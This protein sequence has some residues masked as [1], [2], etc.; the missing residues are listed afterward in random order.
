MTAVAAVGFV[1]LYEVT[2]L[3]SRVSSRGLATLHETIGAA[4]ARARAS[5]SRATAYCKGRTTASGVAVQTRHRRRRPRAAAGR[6][7]HPGRLAA[8]ERYNGI[9][10]IMDTGPA[11]QG[12]QIDLYM[13][14]CNEALR[15]RP[16]ADPPSPCCA[17]AGTRAP[18]RRASRPP[19][20][21]ARSREPEPLPAPLPLDRRR[22][23]RPSA[24]DTRASRRRRGAQRSS[25]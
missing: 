23:T 19:V 5:P 2:V 18:R 22:Q 11:V 9:Y 4:A 13:W 20:P 12:R 16:P 21:Q 7:G 6:L 8:A 10:T 3:D 25:F 1:S 17:S 14:S 15:V 24:A